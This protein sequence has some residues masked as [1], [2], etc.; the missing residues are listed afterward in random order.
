MPKFTGKGKLGPAV[1][2]CRE[3]A[4]MTQAQL[5]AKL[6]VSRSLVC[7]FESGEVSL[8]EHSM[9]AIFRALNITPLQFFSVAFEETTFGKSKDPVKEAKK[10]A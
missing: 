6:K 9:E 8:T 5:A 3:Q 10:I 2:R 4:G 7:Q 1:T